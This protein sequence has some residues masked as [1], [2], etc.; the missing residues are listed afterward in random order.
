MPSCRV[1]PR[2]SGERRAGTV[3][4]RNGAGFGRRAGRRSGAESPRTTPESRGVSGD[5][6][7]V[8]PSE[9]RSKQLDTREVQDNRGFRRSRAT[10]MRYACP[11]S[12]CPKSVR[13]LVCPG[14]F[15]RAPARATRMPGVCPGRNSCALTGNSRALDSGRRQLARPR[16][17]GGFNGTKLLKRRYSSKTIKLDSG[18]LD[19]EGARN[20][21]T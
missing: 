11:L 2:R 9:L 12:E 8:P 16:A 1:A 14:F 4:E 17:I 3:S 5:T 15:G 13:Q 6:V 21:A 18:Q 7:E 10:R 19:I 20:Q